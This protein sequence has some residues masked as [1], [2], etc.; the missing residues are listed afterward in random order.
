MTDTA[1]TSDT[2]LSEHEADEFRQ[3]CIT[4]LDEHATV[5]DRSGHD[6]QLEGFPRR[7]GRGRSRRYPLPQRIWWWWPDARPREDLAGGEGRLRPDGDRVH[8]QPRNVPAD[9]QRVRHA[10][11][12]EGVPPRQHRR[13]HDVVPDVLR[14]WLPVPTSPACRRR[15]NSTA[16]SGSSTVR[17]CGRRSPTSAT[18]DCC[19]ARTDPEQPKHAGISMFILDM[20]AP[21]VEIRPIHQIDGGSHFNEVFFTDVHIPKEW[22]VGEY[23]AGWKMATAML[24]YERVAIGS[25]GAGKIDQPTY[26]TL[27]AG[28]AERVG[29]ARRPR[30]A[31]RPDEDLRDG[32]DE[33]AHRDAH[34]R[35]D[36]IR[37]DTRPGRLAR[38]ALRC[39]HRPQD[40][41]GRA[42]DRRPRDRSHGTPDDTVRSTSASSSTASRPTSP[43]V[44]TRSSATSSATASSACRASRRST[45]AS[46]SRTSRS[47]PRRADRNRPGC[48]EVEHG[49]RRERFRASPVDPSGRRSSSLTACPALRRARPRRDSTSAGIDEIRRLNAERFAPEGLKPPHTGTPLSECYPRAV[50]DRRLPAPA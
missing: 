27:L 26:G 43:A 45:R 32:D 24:M 18:T 4:F 29:Q 20:K 5:D 44:P 41:R 30:R 8:H 7:R 13:P 23:N 36:E 34:P 16:T 1:T 6:H 47:A 14:T 39:D 31:R 19:I 46:R 10:R 15:P 17:R 22:L 25:A 40:A 21:G 49:R 9:A 3:R 12:E 48:P 37:Q 11:A 42:R 35:R 28:A 33:V 38:Q 50:R 2:G